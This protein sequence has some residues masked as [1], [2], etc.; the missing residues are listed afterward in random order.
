MKSPH[1]TVRQALPPS[2]ASAGA[3]L[4]VLGMAFSAT[5]VLA[6]CTTEEIDDHFS[7]FFERTDVLQAPIALSL[8]IDADSYEEFKARS[9]T[10]V[11]P[12]YTLKIDGRWAVYVNTSQ[13][14][15]ADRTLA[16]VSALR[17]NA[18][19]GQWMSAGLHVFELVD[20]TGRTVMRTPA[21]DIQPGQTNHI[22]V[23]GRE[24]DLHHRFFADSFDV[25]PGMQ[26]FTVISVLRT[27]SLEV[28]KCDDANGAGSCVTLAGP[29]EYGFLARGESALSGPASV[30]PPDRASNLYVRLLPTTRDPAPVARRI[31]Y[32]PVITTLV[33]R[34]L[35]VFVGGAP[36][37]LVAAPGVPGR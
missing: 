33:S 5:G 28:L 1:D 35:N 6:T 2:A 16:T 21:Y 29:L 19:V 13:A 3:A 27:E 37:I 4:A 11:Q 32:D 26:R 24:D 14:S 30:S 31:E 8:A 7:L 10:E 9:L 18:L 25:A 15:T 36:A 23:F 17:P 34:D 12:V 22:I 20:G